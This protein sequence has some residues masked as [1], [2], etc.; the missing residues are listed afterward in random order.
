MNSYAVKGINLMRMN[1]DKYGKGK[2]NKKKL[3]RFL[4][5]TFAASLLGVA[6]PACSSMAGPGAVTPIGSESAGP[7]ISLGPGVMPGQTEPVAP[8][9]IYF[10]PSALNAFSG[11]AAGSQVLLPEGYYFNNIGAYTYN[12]MADDL[13]ALKNAYPGMTLNSLGTTVDGRE[14]YYAVAGNPSASRKVLIHASIHAREYITSQLCMRQLAS[15]LEMLARGHSY[16]GRSMNELMQNTC[17]YFVPMVDPD[18]VSLVQFGIGGIGSESVRANIMNM[19]QLDNIQEQDLNEYFRRWKNNASGVNLNRNFD[20]DWEN[21]DDRKY[22]PSSVEYKG[23]APES[24]FESRALA[25]LTRRVRFNR[26]ISY[27]TQGQVIYWYYGK[28][29][30]TTATRKLAQIVKNNSGY[31]IS[32]YYNPNDSAGYKDW[33]I[34]KMGIPSVTVECGIGTSPVE[35]EQIL[36]IWEKQKGVIPDILCDLNGM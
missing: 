18:G 22:R 10:D 32:D 23:P 2:K 19:A 13:S 21:I 4:S 14:L 6:L 16:G 9:E 3:I 25:D 20:A 31:E 15:L 33:A 28:G 30:Y 5:A 35:E 27:H 8:E 29:E 1:L 11:L 34:L 26:T 7:G 24:E 36:T 12:N 17:V